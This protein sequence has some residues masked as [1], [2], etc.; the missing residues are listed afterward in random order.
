MK[1]IAL[2]GQFRTA[3]GKKATK[4][5]RSQDLVPCVIYGVEKDEKGLPTAQ[6][7]VV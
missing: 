6:S 1:E 3:T 7:F 4:A 5:L 2:N